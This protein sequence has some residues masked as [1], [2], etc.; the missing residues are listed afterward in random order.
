MALSPD[1]KTL[2][3]TNAHSDTISLIHTETLR[4]T[5][6]E[7]VQLIAGAERIRIHLAPEDARALRDFLPEVAEHLDTDGTD[8][9]AEAIELVP[10]PDITR[11]GCI[12]R[13]A[14][15]AGE[16]DARIETQ[17]EEIERQLKE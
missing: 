6:A 13:T 3:V 7:A 16:I 8:S 5:V 10:D 1:E 11:G 15:G 17:L 2:A 9:P 4:R 12:V 14:G